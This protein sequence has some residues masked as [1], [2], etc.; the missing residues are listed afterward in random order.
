MKIERFGVLKY[1]ILTVRFSTFRILRR[2]D[3]TIMCG[4]TI[5][6]A[7]ANAVTPGGDFDLIWLMDIS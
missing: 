3:H 6:G 7:A 2:R 4:H 5:G 1:E